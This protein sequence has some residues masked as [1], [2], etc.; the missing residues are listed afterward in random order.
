MT[1]A[2]TTPTLAL[3]P[4]ASGGALAAVWP[5]GVAAL[6]IGLA[7]SLWVAAG[8]RGAAPSGQ[9][10]G[11]AGLALHLAWPPAAAGAGLEVLRWALLLPLL[12]ALAGL[13]R[14]APGRWLRLAVAALGM[15]LLL[16]VG[17][18]AQAAAPTPHWMPLA[19]LLVAVAIWLGWHRQG[20]V[21][22]ARAAEAA[23][24]M[25]QQ[26]QAQAAELAATRQQMQ[27]A[28]ESAEA[29]A[30]ARSS[31]LA[32]ASHDLRQPA[33]ALGLYTAAL[34]AGP[35]AAE[36]AEIV[37]RMQA[38]L[39]ALDA[40]FAALLDV[41]RIDAG[42]VAP[43][44]DTVWL[45]P[46]LHRLALEWAPQAE[47]RGLRLAVHVS[48]PLAVTVTDA[49]LLER[50][51][52]NLLANAIKYTRQGGVLL[53]CRARGA[54]DGTRGW[55]VE[56][57]DTGI[58]IP[59]AEQERVFEEFY[60][61]AGPG[62]ERGQGLGLGLAIVQRLVRLL[63]LRL[64]LRSVPG[65]GS[66]FLLSGLA[67]ARPSTQRAAEARQAMRQLQGLGVAVLE[68]DDDVRDAMHRLLSQWGC[69]VLAGVDAQDL[70]GRF[71]D[72]GPVQALIADLRLA[73]GRLGP[74]EARTLMAAWG[75]SLPMLLVSGE[76]G[77]AGLQA[78]HQSG[79]PVLA[80][81]VSP[82]RLRSWLESV[83]AGATTR[84]PLDK[85]SP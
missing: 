27:R 30:Q 3:E 18:D 6:L 9:A 16:A 35:L 39:A 24:L 80:K 54:A 17:L 8:R 79:Q 61:V 23:G 68:D 47:A 26:L 48:D 63:Q 4:A 74:D 22:E 19:G 13:W 11:A 12:P 85:E 45:A 81:P 50:V 53:A 73:D 60:Q 59:P 46:L 44:W 32:A 82:A 20:H 40:M 71:P 58:G 14:L 25:Q 10:A 56:V 76:T 7:V 55:R 66:V 33:H 62:P 28:V 51:L 21:H 78:L 42:A 37:S 67:A 70:L 77:H 29:A 72:A 31:F 43:Q 34:R 52:R 57:W 65:R 49:L 75:R 64:V 69:R 5:L 1:T 84:S 41:S 38:S 2:L 83:A 15:A 36:Q